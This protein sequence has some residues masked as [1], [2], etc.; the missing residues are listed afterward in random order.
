[1]QMLKAMPRKQWW[2][3]ETPGE[4]RKSNPTLRCVLCFSEIKNSEANTA[5]KGQ[6]KKHGSSDL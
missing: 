5:E 3:Q 4:E 1:M 6:S 2:L